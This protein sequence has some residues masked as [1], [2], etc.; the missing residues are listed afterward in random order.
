M[1]SLMMLPRLMACLSFALAPAALPSRAASSL[2]VSEFT[3]PCLS[4]RC[5]SSGAKP[6]KCRPQVR[7]F[8]LPYLSTGLLRASALTSS[9]APGRAAEWAGARSLPLALPPPGRPPAPAPPP[10]APWATLATLPP[11]RTTPHTSPRSLAGGTDAAAGPPAPSPCRSCCF[12]PCVCCL[13]CCRCCC[14]S[15]ACSSSSDEKSTRA[16]ACAVD[17]PAPHA[18]AAGASACTNTFGGSGSAAGAVASPCAP[19]LA[20]LLAAAFAPP[21]LASGSP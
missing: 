18:G 4:L 14:A 20:R 9:A 13:C 2:A 21:C 1:V 7:H 8:T 3:P 15:V 5:C 10:A 11:L 16:P 12:P 19:L 17:P 6:G